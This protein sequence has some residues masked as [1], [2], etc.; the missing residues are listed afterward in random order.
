MS[1]AFTFIIQVLWL[2]TTYLGVKAVDEL[3]WDIIAAYMSG[4][5]IGVYINY[6]L[7]PECK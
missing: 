2:I 1:A 4:G 6:W 5:V 3:R 7:V